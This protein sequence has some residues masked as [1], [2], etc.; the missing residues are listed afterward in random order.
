ML[1]AGGIQR[2]AVVVGE[3]K[4]MRK[5]DFEQKYLKVFVADIQVREMDSTYT[6]TQHYKMKSKYHVLFTVLHSPFNIHLL[7]YP[8]DVFPSYSHVIF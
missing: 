7:N 6:Q 5:K 1:V 2:R 4:V 8:T 3:F